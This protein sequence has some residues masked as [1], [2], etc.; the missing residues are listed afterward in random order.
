MREFR[1]SSMSHEDTESFQV[2]CCRGEIEQ[3][4]SLKPITPYQGIEIIR[5]CSSGTACKG[6]YCF[7]KFRYNKQ[8]RTISGQQRCFNTSSELAFD[9][10]FEG[11]EYGHYR[12]RILYCRKDFC[13][14]LAVV[15]IGI[16]GEARM[17]TAP[18]VF[19]L[20]LLPS[21]NWLAI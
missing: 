4:T 7:I 14:E 18:M 2:T 17:E 15:K 16:S 5:R 8:R 20:L 6:D 3:Q 21:I 10:V 1:R 9:R 13:N 11:M 12:D 19:L